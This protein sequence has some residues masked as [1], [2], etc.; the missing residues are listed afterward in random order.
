M[1]ERTRAEL[2]A[3]AHEVDEAV[4]AVTQALARVRQALDRLASAH[5]WGTFDTWFGGGL[6]ASLV[7]HDRIA[8]ADGAMRQVD[9]A[10]GV[11]R[12]ELADVGVAGVGDVGV[13]SLARTLDI[14]F[15][16][17]FSD[18]GT[19]SRIKD[20]QSRLTVVDGALRSAHAELVRRRAGLGEQIATR[21]A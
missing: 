13:D 5:S 15:D 3:E 18:W 16:N 21:D 1:T 4:E 20:A 2:E 7:K 10:L 11:A 19:Q 8:E 12:S 17:I 9:A 6:F 14:W